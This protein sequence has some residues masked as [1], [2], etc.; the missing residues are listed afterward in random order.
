MKATNGVTIFGSAIFLP[1][2]VLGIL[3]IVA[4]GG[5][6]VSPTLH[7]IAMLLIGIC[8]VLASSYAFRG[9][10]EHGSRR[11]LLVGMGLLVGT[12]LMVGHMFL[13]E[14]QLG[15]LAA[16]RAE[17][18]FRLGTLVLALFLFLAAGFH[19]KQIEA[20]RRKSIGTGMAV[21]V[22]VLIAGGWL[23]MGSAVENNILVA[24]TVGR[25]T[26]LGRFMQL[27]SIMFLTVAAI[28][29]LHGAFLIRSEAALAVATGTVLVVMAEFSYATIR[30][31]LDSFF[32][33]AH[34]W[35]S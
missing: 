20:S 13:G 29:Y 11:L 3:N 8:G 1:I 21:L 33:A 28:R 16:S 34:L 17:W 22:L 9:F 18:H 35:Y 6:L 27:A 4:V 26:P 15:T 30:Q 25:W 5:V 2:F 14:G 32:W 7:T 19:E 10:R 24:A 23:L 31:P 12:I